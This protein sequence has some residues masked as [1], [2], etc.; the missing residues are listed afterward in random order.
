MP[1][2]IVIKVTRVDRSSLLAMGIYR[3]QYEKGT[4]VKAYAGSVGCMC[5]ETM[6]VAELFITHVSMI[7]LPRVD[8]LRYLRVEGIGESR[9]PRW[10]SKY[11]AEEYL[12]RFYDLRANISR[13]RSP[14]VRSTPFGTICY[15]EIL[16][17]D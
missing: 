1:N 2:P 5:F 3:L 17:L 12:V 15:P 11:L 10:I 4:R 9:F 14:H 8:Q 16:V 13:T 6:E 7:R